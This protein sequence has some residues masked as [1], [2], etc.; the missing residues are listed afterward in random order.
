MQNKKNVIF[1][2]LD[3]LRADILKLYG[4]SLKLN[5]IDRIAQ[6][7]RVY[8]MALAPGTYTL[9]SH[10][11][12]FL[13]KRP[14]RI[15]SL[16]ASGFKSSD[17]M[18]DPFARKSKY[19]QGE[20]TLAG[21]MCA[22]GYNS[23]LFSNNPFL[24]DYTG[25][26]DG[27]SY[28]SNLFIDKMLESNRAHVKAILKLIENDRVRKS[29]IDIA[30]MASLP[31]TKDM[32]DSTYMKLRKKLNFYFSK[33]YGY[34]NLDKGAEETNRQI[35]EYAKTNKSTRNFIF[36]N[37]MEGHEG[38]PTDMVTK[39]Y[40]EQDKWLY[41]IGKSDLE[42]IKHVME[43]YFR[44]IRYLDSEIG[45]TMDILKKSGLLDDSTVIITSDHGQGFMEHGQMFH[46]IH[47]YNEVIHVPLIIAD[48]ESGKQINCKQRIENPF[49]IMNLNQMIAGKFDQNHAPL[50]CDHVGITEVWDSYLLNKI[51]GRSKSAKDILK[52]KKELDMQATAIIGK[53]YKLMHFYGLRKDEL[54]DITADPYETHDI[55]DS[56]RDIA[57]SLLAYNNIL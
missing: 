42:D 30:C 16:K 56:K 19:I 41:M 2:M 57:H 29:L 27:F 1:I 6:Y 44:R 12:L 35:L 40:V 17:I 10:L 5:N 3:T 34:Y 45:K 54:Y 51:K 52:K 43:A 55:I 21:M 7:G 8:D 13:G 11:S 31:M 53:R 32:L 25:L 9:P 49:S 50:V 33:E 39:K 48:F 28:S 24:S 47:P 18:T 4:G 22:F 23:A 46:N 37:Y 26:T 15:K 20:I 14:L 38:Y 36:V